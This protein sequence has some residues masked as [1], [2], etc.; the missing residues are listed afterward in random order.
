MTHCRGVHPHE[1]KSSFLMFQHIGREMGLRSIHSSYEEA[2]AYMQQHELRHMHYSPKNAAVAQE[3]IAVVMGLFP[4]CLHG[5]L[6]LV[7]HT[8]AGPTLRTA[9]VW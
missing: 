9:M 3:S 1:K 6:R 4:Q 7:L 8:L 2:E 5:A